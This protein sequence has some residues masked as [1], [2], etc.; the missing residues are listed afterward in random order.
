MRTS[1]VTIVIAIANQID[2]LLLFQLL[3]WSWREDYEI[4]KCSFLRK[5]MEKWRPK[6]ESSV[7]CFYLNM[8]FELSISKSPFLGNR[9]HYSAGQMRNTLQS[10]L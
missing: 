2:Y 10:L 9:Y 6:R 8:A 7:P 3:V 4:N 5:L 1:N